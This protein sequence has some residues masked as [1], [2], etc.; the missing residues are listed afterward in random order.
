MQ[1]ILGHI[2]KQYLCLLA[3][4]F[5]HVFVTSFDP[6]VVYLLFCFCFWGVVFVSWGTRSGVV[7]GRYCT[8]WIILIDLVK[9]K[10]T[11][12]AP[13]KLQTTFSVK[14]RTYCFAILATQPKRQFSP[15][16]L[17]LPA[18]KRDFPCSCGATPSRTVPKTQPLYVAFSLER[19]DLRSQKEGILRKKIAWRKEGWTE[20]EQ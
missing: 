4:C 15:T 16:H 11:T 5:S 13:L 9:D 17:F 20:P 14:K 8:K 3:S 2:F 18:R 19:V 10:T 1:T 6:M 12:W 7:L